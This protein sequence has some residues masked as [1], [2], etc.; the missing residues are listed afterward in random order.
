M[1]LDFVKNVWRNRDASLWLVFIRL[2]LGL[3][4]FIAGLHKLIDPTYVGGM[5]G[6]LSFFASGNVNNAWYVNLTNNIFIPNAEVFAWL[7]SLGEL[8]IGLGLI[9]GIFVNFSALIGVF[10]NLNFYFAASW[11]SASTQSINWIMAAISL[12]FILSPGVK[13]LG[14]DMLIV[15]KVPKLRRFLIDWF[16]FDKEKQKT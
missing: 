6:T 1:S 14:I 2:L 9:L 4:W 16:G 5:A 12:I 8:L 7:V 11:L 15:D 3:E 13:N 10:L